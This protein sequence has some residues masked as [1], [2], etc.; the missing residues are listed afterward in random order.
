MVGSH[1][2]GVIKTENGYW[3]DRLYF[4]KQWHLNYNSR[5]VGDLIPGSS[6]AEPRGFGTNIV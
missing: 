6:L 3:L 4:Q 2:F 1:H 5:D